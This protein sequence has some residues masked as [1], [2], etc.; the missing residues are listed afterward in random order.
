MRLRYKLGL[1]LVVI[2]LAICLMTY[3][4]YALWVVNLKGEENI[5]ETGCFSISFTELSSSISLSITYPMSDERALTQTPY[6]FKI[7]NTCSI[8]SS[9]LVTLNTLT[10]N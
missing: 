6:S 8:A 9:Y 1:S 3:Q 7:K 2:C 4:S 10:T 5:V